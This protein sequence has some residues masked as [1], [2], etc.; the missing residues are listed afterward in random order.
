VQY[1]FY[2]HNLIQESLSGS[3]FIVIPF[4]SALA[5]TWLYNSQNRSINTQ[6]R[7]HF[8]LK[9]INFLQRLG[10]NPECHSL[11]QLKALLPDSRQLG[12]LPQIPH[13]LRGRSPRT[14]SRII[15]T[16]SS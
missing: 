7:P 14:P 10:A 4:S 5:E 15:Q 6:K 1:L 11:R 12:A 16:I 3:P 9:I 2:E 13:G 8:Y